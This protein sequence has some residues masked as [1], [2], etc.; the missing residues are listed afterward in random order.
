MCWKCD[1]RSDEEIDRAY[2]LMMAVDGYIGIQVADPGEPGW[3]YTV[4]LTESFGH[5]E[6]I[7]LDVEADVQGELIGRLATAV[8][9]Q[10]AVDPA[11]L[12]D[13]DVEL[14]PVLDT[15]L[16]DGLVA[17][18]VNRCHRF[19]DTGEYLQILL[20]R[21]WFCSCHA[22]SQRRLDRPGA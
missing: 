15:H 22:H 19:P 14:L 13:L 7:C 21:S 8:R 20:G 17:V 16:T 4:G 2:E 18:F 11:L 6:L 9:E 1:G 5:P 10:G 3:T 12:S